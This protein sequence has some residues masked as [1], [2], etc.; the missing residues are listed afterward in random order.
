MTHDDSTRK[1]VY[2]K[3]CTPGADALRAFCL[4]HGVTVAAFIDAA[5]HAL[6]DLEKVPLPELELRFPLAAEALRGARCI[7]AERRRREPRLDEPGRNGPR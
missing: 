7:D 6:A 4:G 5:S 1:T 3:L 2:A